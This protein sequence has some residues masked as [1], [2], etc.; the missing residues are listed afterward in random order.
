[1]LFT[2]HNLTSLAGFE[3]S[4]SMHCLRSDWSNER[5][6]YDDTNRLR[7]AFPGNT[8]PDV[9]NRITITVSTEG[10]LFPGKARQTCYWFASIKFH[11]SKIDFTGNLTFCNFIR[12][13][14]T[15]GMVP[16]CT[17]PLIK[18]VDQSDCQ[19]ECVLPWSV[20]NEQE[21]I[22]EIIRKTSIVKI[23]YHFQLLRFDHFSYFN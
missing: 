19:K 5:L 12:L 3:S 13:Q 15:I 14:N 10:L 4:Y 18:G 6:C 17:N 16:C 9:N 1:M 22:H 20:Y 11:V 23:I 2:L 7:R 8:I 21:K